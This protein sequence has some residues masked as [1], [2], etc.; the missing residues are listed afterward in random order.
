MEKQLKRVFL[1]TV[2]TFFAFSIRLKSLDIKGPALQVFTLNLVGSFRGFSVANAV[3]FPCLL[4]LFLYIEKKL[5]GQ[6]KTD[7]TITILSVIFALFMVFGFSFEENNSWSLVMGLRKAEA[8][9]A[10]MIFLGY[11][12]LFKQ[13]LRYLYFL[14]DKAAYHPRKKLCSVKKGAGFRRMIMRLMTRQPFWTVLLTLII[15]YIPYAVVSYPAIFMGDTTPQIGQAFSELKL[16]MGYMTP[17][18]LLSDAVYINQHHPVVHTM[19]IHWCILLGDRVLHSFNVGIFIYCAIQELCLMTAIAYAT[20]VVFRKT[21]K[22]TCYIAGVLLYSFLHPLIHNYMFLVTKDIIYTAFIVLLLVNLYLLMSDQEKIERKGLYIKVGIACIGMLLFRNDSRYVLI[23]SFLMIAFSCRRLRKA[24]LV[25]SGF[26]LLFSVLFFNILLPALYITPGSKREMLS[27]PFQQTAR[28]VLYHE[29]EVTEEEKNAID[30]VLDYDALAEKYDPN[31]SDNV[32]STFHEDASKE[33]LL[34]YFR[35][36]K[37]MLIKHPGTYIQATMNNYYQYFFPGNTRFIRFSYDW[38]NTC[39]GRANTAL[40]PMARSF[41]YPEKTAAARSFCDQF[42]KR[43]NSFPV[44]SLLM[45]P[46]VYTWLLMIMLFYSFR[47]KNQKAFSIVV[48]PL[49]ILLICI[50]GPCNGD[51]GRYTFPIVI[52]LPFLIPIYLDLMNKN[53]E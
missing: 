50:L 5:V 41:S 42:F 47:R 4:L 45:T 19:L 52:T 31:K 36:W 9:K 30:G 17:D 39:M 7:W 2:I 27:V 43:I 38:S 28:Y 25:Y 12:I 40:E 32:K 35:A 21:G 10:V 14:L 8:V 33:D 26:V 20:S 22:S 6:R 3:M 29:K 37:A 1:E 34:R 11:F 15:V 23:L 46:A 51:Y 49:V 24:A 44:I 13:G 53:K 18:R 16:A 48:M